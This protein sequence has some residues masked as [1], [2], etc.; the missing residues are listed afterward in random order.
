[1][2]GWWSVAHLRPRK[3]KPRRRHASH[4]TF[5]EGN[6]ELKA[7]AQESFTLRVQAGKPADCGHYDHQTC[8]MGERTF[9]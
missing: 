8:V 5:G 6:F 7:K 1:M 3:H 4:A 9:R 2:I